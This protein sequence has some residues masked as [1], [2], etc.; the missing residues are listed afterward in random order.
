M[1]HKRMLRLMREEQLLCRPR[2]RKVRITDSHHGFCIYQ[3]LAGT[4]EL[5]GVNQ[6]WASDIT[7][8]GLPDEYIYLASVVDVYSRKCVG[9]HI[10]DSLDT[11]LALIALQKAVESRKHLGLSDLI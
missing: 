4:A 6:L 1:N 8:I 11:S 9:W 7:Y 10:G 3:N 5:T 2:K